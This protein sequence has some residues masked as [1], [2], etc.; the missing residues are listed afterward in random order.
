MKARAAWL[1]TVSWLM[2][3][4]ACAAPAGDAAD[5][6]RRAAADS[7]APA[8]AVASRGCTQEDLPALIVSLPG[9]EPG[10]RIVIEIAGSG[11]LRPGTWRLSPLR[12]DPALPGRSLARAELLRGGR[13]AGWLSGELVL[14]RIAA[15]DR[16]VGRY[17][18]TGPGGAVIG[19]R[20]EAQWEGGRSDCG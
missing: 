6:D 7:T 4:A 19:G 3:P 16:A 15:G 11:P 17:S 1:W 2:V 9:S 8:A 10:T 12:R 13:S 20:F 5:R 14:E 18:F